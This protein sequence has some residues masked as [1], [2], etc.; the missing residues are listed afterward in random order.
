MDNW[1]SV[2]SSNLSRIRY[3]N[4]EQVMDV[5]FHGGRTYRYF[6]VSF[7]EFHRLRDASSKG[8]YF[9]DQIKGRYRYE[10]LR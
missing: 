1:I 6:N 8:E 9:A 10:E 5:E 4:D 7:E 2:Q 3:D